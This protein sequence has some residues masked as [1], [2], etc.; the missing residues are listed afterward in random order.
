MILRLFIACEFEGNQFAVDQKYIQSSSVLCSYPELFHLTLKFLGDVDDAKVDSIVLRLQQVLH[1]PFAVESGNI[2]FFPNSKNPRVIWRGIKP[3][4]QCKEL[5]E[6]IDKVLSELFPPE[7]KFKPHITL[8][9]VKKFSDEKGFADIEKKLNNNSHSQVVVDTF[10]LISSDLSSGK[11]KYTILSSF[12]LRQ[13][14]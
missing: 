14:L 2:G 6:K 3:E 5:Q 4:E 12:K 13:P 9:R 10:H 11:P 1:K 7:Q 8:A